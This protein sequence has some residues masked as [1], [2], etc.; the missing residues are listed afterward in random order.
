MNNKDIQVEF[1]KWAVKGRGDEMKEN[2]YYI[3]SMTID[4]M[5]IRGNERV[6]DVGCGNGW[7]VRLLSK[8]IKN[9]LVVGIDISPAMIREAVIKSSSICNAKF[10]IGDADYIPYG[11]KIFDIVL[12]VETFYYYLNPFKVIYEMRRVLKDGGKAY[13]IVDLYKENPYSMKWIKFLKIPVTPLG[14]RDYIDLINSAGL[15]LVEQRRLIDER[16]E[17]VYKANKNA[18][19]NKI[20]QIGFKRLG[21]L[22]TIGER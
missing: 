15:K 8:M 5:N 13:I 14:E 10:Y 16:D 6:L 12:C 3:T 9:G 22:L 17:A 20:D 4:M 11:D 21:S 2:H 7:T 1:D 18:F 19:N